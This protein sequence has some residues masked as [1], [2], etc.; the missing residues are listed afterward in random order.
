MNMTTIDHSRFKVQSS[1]LI[2]ARNFIIHSLAA[3]VLLAGCGKEEKQAKAA[4]EVPVVELTDVRSL[5]PSLQAVLPGELKPWNKTHL[6]PKVKGYVGSVLVDRGTVV[7]KGQVLA[8]LEAP[9]MVAT[10]NHVRA[11]VASAEATLIEQRAKQKASKTTYRRIVETSQTPGAVAANELDI[12]YARMLSDSALARAAEENLHAAQAQLNAQT[13]LVNYLAVKA[14]F[15]GTI[16]ERNISPGD[17]AGPETASKPMFVLEDRGRLRL[18]VAVP[19][20]LSNSISSNSEVSFTL[21][22]DP[23]RQYKATFARSANTLQE[24]NRSMMVEFDF[25][26]RAGDLKAGMYAEVKLPVLRNKPTLFVPR[27]AVLRST[28]GVFLVRVNNNAAEW[29]PVQ[30]GNSL[31]SLIEVFGAIQ[32]GDRIVRR[33]HDELRNGQA[34]KIKS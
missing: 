7:K 6:F 17:L 18:T 12:A 5:Q 32:A 14:P 2:M 34:I 29:I 4:E 3:T 13:Q 21:Q 15:D 8:T 28:E 30:Q 33:A 22:A 27:T 23:L 24:N 19:E 31:D 11:Q 25:D 20:N 16:T 10:L 26:N 9:E 1:K